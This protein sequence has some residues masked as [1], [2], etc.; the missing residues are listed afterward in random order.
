M[1]EKLRDRIAVRLCSWILNHVA[2]EDCRLAVTG[3][4][5]L[6]LVTAAENELSGQDV[7]DLMESLRQMVRGQTFPAYTEEE[8]NEQR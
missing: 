1:K 6:G 8:E 2:S 4:L 7:H 5:K 3:A